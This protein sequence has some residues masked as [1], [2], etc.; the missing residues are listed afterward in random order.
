M[1]IH[2]LE[3]LSER[4][5][6]VTEGLSDDLAYQWLTE[7]EGAGTPHGLDLDD[8][9]SEL[10]EV[11]WDAAHVVIRDLIVHDRVRFKPKFPIC[12]DLI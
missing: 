7:L 8:K 10:I 1:G 6:D 5:A 4:I 3:H 2:D 9:R 12:D 11:F